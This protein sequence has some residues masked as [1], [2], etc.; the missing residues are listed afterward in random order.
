M[1]SSPSPTVV[2]RIAQAISRIEAASAA[3]KTLQLGDSDAEFSQLRKQ[4]DALRQ[5]ALAVLS[6]LDSALDRL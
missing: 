3:E 1:T 5:D 4:H 6:A 2:D